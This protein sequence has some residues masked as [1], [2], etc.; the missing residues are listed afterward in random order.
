M[1]FGKVIQK[2]TAFVLVTLFTRIC[3]KCYFFP[4]RIIIFRLML[5]GFLMCLVGILYTSTALAY[6][7][8]K[9]R[10]TYSI[11]VYMMLSTSTFSLKLKF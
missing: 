3:I 8:H 6:S 9:S 10:E 2:F 4:Y 5:K 11:W 7:A 1:G